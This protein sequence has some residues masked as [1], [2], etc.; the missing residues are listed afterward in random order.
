[1]PNRPDDGFQGSLENGII[2]AR[3]GVRRPSCATHHFKQENDTMHRTTTWKHLGTALAGG[4]LLAGAALAAD[5]AMSAKPTGSEFAA[6]DTNNDGKISL[7]EYTAHAK[8]KFDSMDTDHDGKVTLA[9]LNAAYDKMGGKM[10]GTS[11]ADRL[12][13][14][15]TN[16]DGVI[17]ADEYQANAKAM[18]EKL[19]T[20]KDGFLSKAELEAGHSM[21]HGH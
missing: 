17:S 6:M 5:N 8:A 11:A 19:D 3:K 15:D 18:F 10:N 2:P 16:G 12:K 4:L 21:H 9:E 7:D 13:K 14:L 20:N 1:L